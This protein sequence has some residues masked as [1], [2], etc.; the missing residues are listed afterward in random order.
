MNKLRTLFVGI[1]FSFAAATGSQGGD[2]GFFASDRQEVNENWEQNYESD[3]P[4]SIRETTQR[5]PLGTVGLAILMLGAFAGCLILE[6]KHRKEHS[7][8]E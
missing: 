2:N 8:H 3:A 7:N 1:L 5:L 6:A 4:G